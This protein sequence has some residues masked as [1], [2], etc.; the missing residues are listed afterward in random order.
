MP[1]IR[2]QA[3]WAGFALL[4]LLAV[5]CGPAPPRHAALLIGVQDYQAPGV[6]DLAGPRNDV[7]AVRALLVRRFGFPVD[8]VRVLQDGQATRQGILAALDRLAADAEPGAQVVVHF[9]G[10]GS[11]VADANGDEADGWDESLLA[12]DQRGGP[13]GGDLLDETLGARIAAVAEKGAQVTVILDACHSGTGLRTGPGVRAAPPLGVAP[14]PAAG[15]MVGDPA[16]QWPAL[17]LLTAGRAGQRAREVELADGR[18]HGALTWALVRT[19]E[20]GPRTATWRQ[21]MARVRAEVEG[22]FPNQQPQ[23]E[24]PGADRLPFGGGPETRQAERIVVTPAAPGQAHLAAGQVHGVTVGSRYA[25]LDAGG[26]PAGTLTVSAVAAAHA[27]GPTDARVAA[28]WTARLDTWVAPPHRLALA[29]DDDTLRE[30][31]ARWPQLAPSRGPAWLTAEA[32]AGGWRLVS[33]GAPRGPVTDREGVVRQALAWA[34]WHA[35]WALTSRDGL[36]VSVNL[37][38][39]GP[40]P[41]GAQRTLAVHNGSQR[42]LYLN[43]LALS[44]DGQ[45][46]VL[47]PSPGA[48][49]QIEAGATWRVPLR[50]TAAGGRATVERL[51]I[52]FTPT[53]ADFGPVVQPPVRDG[54]VPRAFG[55]HPLG[56]WIA[57]SALG[58]RAG[59]VAVPQDDWAAREVVVF[60]EPRENPAMDGVKTP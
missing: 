33:G 40:V 2:G 56:R 58:V 44:A 53:P 43:V 42:R 48:V 46:A 24:G 15:G 32:V 36:E 19:L 13:D 27:E 41:D 38:P 39:T 26:R 59:P 9:S 60:V 57:A 30:A 37:E 12:V 17:V 21:V 16:D 3:A 7:A 54:A 23:L 20:R 6:T 5:G 4:A 34:R 25:L 51:K 28:G 11:Q 18:V 55:G 14:V 10:H 47:Y 22:L 8:R 1:L 45:V 50:F 35:L 49:E 29:V 31:L 52:L